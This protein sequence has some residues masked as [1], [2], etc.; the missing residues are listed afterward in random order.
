MLLPRQATDATFGEFRFFLV[1][2]NQKRVTKYIHYSVLRKAKTIGGVLLVIL[3]VA[4]I[5]VYFGR[6]LNAQILVSGNAAAQEILHRQIN[7][8]CSNILV[9]NASS[10]IV[11]KYDGHRLTHVGIDAEALGRLASDCNVQCQQDVA[12]YDRIAV[13]VPVGA[14]TGSA[15]FADKGHRTT[16]TMHVSY[17]I[18]T[19]YTTTCSA[20]GIN[21]IR[22]AVYLVVA[23]V[24]HV[25]IPAEVQDYT[26]TY[27]LP[28]CEMM[29]S[30]DVPN[31][32]VASEDATNYLDLLP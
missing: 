15:Y 17:D 28:V 2:A 8:T 4:A 9:Q 29:Y 32:Y 27:Y 20:V 5:V 3:A 18:D 10:Y 22:Y 6:N 19:T 7:L 11:E 23:A 24:A 21:Q 14:M 31:V 13:S 1:F 25:T 12:Q 26:Y 16:Y 30:A